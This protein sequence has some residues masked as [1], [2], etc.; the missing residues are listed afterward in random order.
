MK[1]T[2]VAIIHPFLYRYARGIE[3]FTFNL[4]DALTAR[5][6]EVHLL[7]W[8]WKPSIRIDTLDS[9]VL[10]HIFP[11]SRYFAAKVIVPFY[12]MHLLRH[13]YDFVWIYFADY[14]EAGA[15]N[16]LRRQS[17][18]IVFHY[19]YSQVPHRFREFQRTGLAKRAARVVAVSKFAA[20]GVLEQLG[21]ECVIIRHGVDVQRFAPNSAVRLN[22]RESLGLTADAPVLVTAAALEE[23]KGVQ[24]VLRALP[25]IL[26]QIPRTIYLVLGDGPYRTSLEEEARALGV[27]ANVRFLGAQ[28]DV[29]P[30]YQAAD[31]FILLSRG[32]AMPNA[33]LEAMAMGL[34]LIVAEQRPFDE[35]LS[36]EYGICVPERDG[37]RVARAVV[38][39]LNDPV[40]RR[41]MR[42]AG[43][44]RA[45]ADFTWERV[46][47]EYAQL[48]NCSASG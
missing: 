41:A 23:R 43:R 44:S 1:R 10:V 17:F 3:R 35:I 12:V 45:C 11:T 37:N 40:R 33:P 21:R 14:G 19:P 24:W 26:R 4:A 22:V 13:A 30:F 18:G 32:E 20:E 7:T 48:M 28:A 25:E 29:V 27:Q 5:G 42:Q 46:G 47:E 8:C 36:A 39:L 9:R 16:L 15:L 6:V 2:R 34:P 31:I 38:G